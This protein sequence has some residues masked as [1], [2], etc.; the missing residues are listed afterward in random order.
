LRARTEA[1]CDEAQR[2]NVP[3]TPVPASPAELIASE[4]MQAR[5]V[6]EHGVDGQEGILPAGYFEFDD[7]RV[8]VPPR[9]SAGCRH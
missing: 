6:R 9:R 2:R 3:V 4:P 8:G 5:H 7:Q 1:V